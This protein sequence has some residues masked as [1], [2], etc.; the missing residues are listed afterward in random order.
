L[1]LPVCPAGG[2]AQS[3]PAATAP[4]SRRP[5]ALPFTCNPLPR[6]FIFPD[7]PA[8][9]AGRYSRCTSFSLGGTT[10]V[11]LSPD[12][13]LAVMLNGDGIARVVDVPSQQVVA[14]LAPAH[15][16]VTRVAF[17]PSGDSLLTVAGGE[18]EATLWRTGTWTPIWTVT[19]PGH[20]Y[21]YMDGSGGAIAFSPDGGSVVA[22]PGNGLHLLDAATGAL[23]AS[24]AS[25]AL[26]DV[27]YA[28]GGRRI[29][30]ADALLTGHCVKSPF[31]GKVVVLDP[32]TLASLV[33]VATWAGYSSDLTTPAFR[34]S[35]NDDLVLV[36]PHMNDPDQGVKGFRISD[37]SVRPWT[38]AAQMPRAFMPDGAHL[39]TTGDGELRLVRITDAAIL[40]RASAAVSQSS[41][42]AVSGD[43]GTVAVGAGGPDLLHVWHTNDSYAVGVCAMAGVTPGQVVLS[44]DGRL[45]AVAM[46][47][48][49]EVRRPEDGGL[50]G[51]VSG[52]GSG[53]YNMVLSPTGRYVAAQFGQ[54]DS[55]TLFILY[56]SDNGAIADL[57]RREPGYWSAFAF[58]PDEQAFY[59]VRSAPGATST[60]LERVDLTGGI[61]GATTTR[62]L[63]DY[64]TLVGFSRGCPVLWNQLTGVYRSCDSCD[65]QPIT[66]GYPG[67]VVSPDGA[68]L[69]AGDP[70]PGGNATL[71][72][73]PPNQR[74]FRV[75]DPPEAGPISIPVGVS[76]GGRRVVVG[77]SANASCYAGHAFSAEVRDGVTGD[78]LDSLPPQPTSV[79]GDLT[80]IAYRTQIWCGR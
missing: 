40:A 12:G 61:R 78:L 24:Y 4:A 53:V 1:T 14:A 7:D 36:P 26:L 34:A 73:L 35:P 18:H 23:R 3:A 55:N 21:E 70:S 75:F 49:I 50:V 74:S 60:V 66:G 22:S 30:A 15:A 47:S 33:T 31:G 62:P 29:V 54:L 56:V 17:S 43:G 45:A 63:P 71:W 48:S 25:P 32:D 19:L 68:F 8:A 27:A 20:P 77:A 38:A 79:S 41:V 69:L 76:N 46:G 2:P 9:T 80:R 10:A 44:A 37:G 28:W 11:A 67:P 16:L 42:F 64:T 65:E 39:L 59:D 5:T 72:S 6:S 51:T 52:N 57:S 58:S 13:R